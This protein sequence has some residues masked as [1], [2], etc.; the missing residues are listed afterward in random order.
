MSTPETAPGG[1]SMHLTFDMRSE[2][3]CLPTVRAAIAQIA[4]MVGWSESESRCITMAVDEAVANIIR[5][6]YHGRPDG[7]IELHCRA[8]EDQLEIRIRD[9]GDP[10][11]KSR[12]CA[13]DPGC[14]R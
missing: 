7:R 3:R 10:P 6:A 1:A 5:H 14:D 8:G 12:I 13:H 2:A 11:D 4:V 9:T